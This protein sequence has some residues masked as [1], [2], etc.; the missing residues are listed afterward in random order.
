MIQGLRFRRMFEMVRMDESAADIRDMN[1][2]LQRM[3]EE[4]LSK[5]LVL[6]KVGLN[7]NSIPRYY[8][9]TFLEV[10]ILAYGIRLNCENTFLY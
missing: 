8:F 10:S 2:R 3:L 1:R 7:S 9:R 6:Q 4:T 5:N